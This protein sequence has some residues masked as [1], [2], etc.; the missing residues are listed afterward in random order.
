MRQP[1]K[2]P[3]TSPV[4]SRPTRRSFFNHSLAGLAG[5]ALGASCRT[6]DEAAPLFIRKEAP[7]A[8]Q[9]YSVREAVQEDF[10]G[11]LSAIARMGYD[12]VEFAGYHDYSAWEL[13]RML[14]ENGLQSAGC[15]VR[16]PSL[17][18]D[19]F[20]RTVE[21]S[22]ALGS[23]FVVVPLHTEEPRTTRDEWLQ[24]A[25]TFNDVSERLRPY[26]MQVGIHNFDREFQ[27]VEGELPWHILGSYTLAEVVLQL[28]TA[29]ATRGGGDVI[30]LLEPYP[31]RAQSVHL[32][33]HAP[34]GSVV[35]PGDGVVPFRPLLELLFTTGGVEWLII[36]QE[37]HPEGYTAL[38][39]VESCL[40]RLQGFLKG[41]SLQASTA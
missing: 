22:Q 38:E 9:L 1:S 29:A 8:L 15:H 6:E 37:R 14:D 19:E 4:R 5:I 35:L 13:R 21:F 17:L 27:P 31:G 39:S 11:V 34:D 18:G 16:L 12:G 24:L 28:D 25:E 41:K 30:S 26:G 20:E 36:E 23:P 2:K 32:E 33:D 7:I 3:D 40:R 10:P